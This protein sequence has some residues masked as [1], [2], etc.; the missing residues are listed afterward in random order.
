MSFTAELKAEIL[1]KEQSKKCC[2]TAMLAGL[3]AFSSSF[4]SE[5]LKIVSEN[6]AVARKIVKQLKKTAGIQVGIEV[7]AHGGVKKNDTFVITV[8]DYTKLMDALCLLKN[9]EVCF[10]QALLENECCK[11]AFIKGAFLGGG[12]VSDPRK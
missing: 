8:A 11:K 7:K 1:G 9:G 3:I 5:Y 4:K 2:D 12:S 10:P 6:R